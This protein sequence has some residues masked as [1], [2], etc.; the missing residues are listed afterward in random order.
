M[1]NE[2]ALLKDVSCGNEK[3][4]RELFNSYRGKVYGYAF[5]ILKS[6]TDAEDVLQDVFLKLWLHGR[7]EELEN[8]EGYL[9]TMTRNH[10]FKVLRRQNLKFASDNQLKIR[11]TEA[12]N[13]TE[14]SLLLNDSQLIINQAIEQLPPRQKLVYKLCKHEGL[15]YEAAAKVL[16]ISPLT[17]KTHMQQSL[18]FLRNYLTKHTDVV[19]SLLIFRVFIEIIK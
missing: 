9:K 3:D 8:F 18:R 16:S 14:E 12:H 7:V 11:W 13:E 10:V 6:E 5:K 1:D 19:T 17:V 2:K 4:F 15:K